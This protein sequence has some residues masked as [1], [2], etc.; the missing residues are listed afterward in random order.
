MERNDTSTYRPP[1]LWVSIPVILLCLAGGGWVIHLYVKTSPLV[2]DRLVVGDPPTAGAQFRNAVA[3][4]AQGARNM[5]AGNRPPRAGGANPPPQPTGNGNIYSL[6]T[7]KAKFQFW[8]GHDGQRPGFRQA[9]YSGNGLIPREVTNTDYFL[10]TVLSPNNTDHDKLIAAIGL[11][12]AQLTQLRAVPRVSAMVVA[13]ADRTRL[14]AD[15]VAYQ[16]AVTKERSAT[17]D[18]ATLA[19]AT[20]DALTKLEATAEDVAE[21]SAE[22]MTKAYAAEAEKINAIITPDQWKQFQAFG[23][24]R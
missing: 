16:N 3:Q 2:H 21:R 12:P 22:P 6:S 9:S 1:P 13:D 7:K 10:A 23:G 20:A 18:K 15:Y 14:T 19:T 4:G 11:T 8:T 24:G 17:T 5:F